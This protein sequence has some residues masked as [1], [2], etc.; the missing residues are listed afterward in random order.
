MEYVYLVSG[1]HRSG[2]SMMMKCMESTGMDAIYD[3]HEDINQKWRHDDYHPNPNGFYQPSPSRLDDK[4]F[5]NKYKN[6]VIKYDWNKLKK[7]P[8][9]EYRLIFMVRDP[10][11]ILKSMK[12]FSKFGS[13][14]HHEIAARIYDT[15]LP[16]ILD[17]INS[18]SNIDIITI[19]YNKVI[20][21][22]EKEFSK[23]KVWNIDYHKMINIV[24]K[25]LYRSVIV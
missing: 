18:Y 20:E 4:D 10:Q 2:T 22:P 15:F 25:K 6:A 3:Y 14:N 17:R 9:G 11:E 1:V 12:S 19:D 5:F 21:N 23:L 13:F 16:S 24:D 7:I 8:Q